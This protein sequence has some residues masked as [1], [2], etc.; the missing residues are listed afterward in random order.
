[1][2]SQVFSPINFRELWY[3]YV[4]H[5]SYTSMPFP[6][7]SFVPH[8]PVERNQSHASNLR[9]VDRPMVQTVPNRPLPTNPL[10]STPSLKEEGGGGRAR[11]SSSQQ[12]FD[13]NLLD[14]KD[15]IRRAHPVTV[16]VDSRDRDYTMFPNPHA[17]SI[18]LP[19]TLHNVTHARLMSCELPTSFYVFKTDHG[20]TKIRLN[21]DG[22]IKD[23]TIP[24]GNY[25]FELMT[26]TLQ[27]VCQ[28]AFAGYAFEVTF[29]EVTQKCRI[30]VFLNESP[31]SWSLD[32][33]ED[34]RLSTAQSINR[35]KETGWGLAYFLG[36]ERDR[37]LE[38]ESGFIQGTRP[39]VMFPERYI[40]LDIRGLGKAQ[41][42][43]LFGEREARH[44]FAKIPFNVGTSFSSVFYDKSLTTNTL[45]PPVLSLDTLHI[46]FRFHDRTPVDFH[47]FEHSLTL[48]FMV[49]E[50][51]TH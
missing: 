7:S 30:G 50:V 40:L 43:G 27:V 33:R 45:S 11:V 3:T 41:E 39:A 17:Y 8:R 35:D 4:V 28:A 15:M 42:A 34:A 47:S 14:A 20:T 32:T 13:G 46:E 49:S 51:Q 31:V 22:N 19:H 12:G 48:E 1:M 9:L 2:K 23:V 44:T 29:D 24:D 38:S 6:P 26:E 36:F 18:R 5:A 37:L 16:L 25:S 21:V 10:E